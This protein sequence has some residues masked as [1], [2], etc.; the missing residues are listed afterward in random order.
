MPTVW[1]KDNGVRKPMTISQKAY[2]DFL[3]SKYWANPMI[4]GG[5]LELGTGEKKESQGY[6]PA[7]ALGTEPLTGEALSGYGPGGDVSGMIG[8]ENGTMSIADFGKIALSTV[9]HMNPI[10]PVLS[11]A[12]A[13]MK[14]ENALNS[15]SVPQTGW[16]LLA[17]ALGLHAGMDPSQIGFM[18]AT[19]NAHSINEALAENG[20]NPAIGMPSP[21]GGNYGGGLSP[22]YGGGGYGMPGSEGVGGIW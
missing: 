4:P 13:Q 10:T 12:L 6:G 17:N 9:L 7:S 5:G 18:Q 22:D 8:P 20:L 11:A 16:N 14:G 1:Y 15:N 3:K 21:F 2:K 19:M